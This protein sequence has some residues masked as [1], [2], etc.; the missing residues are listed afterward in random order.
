MKAKL[1]GLLGAQGAFL[2]LLVAGAGSPASAQSVEEL[3]D[4]TVTSARVVTV[5]RSQIGGPKQEISL[6]RGV[7]A[8][9]L[10][11]ATPE[12]MAALETRVQQMAD[13]LCAELDRLYPMEEPEARTCARDAVRRTMSGVRSRLAVS[14]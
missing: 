7:I 2:A 5:G 12:G 8:D 11:L 9:D 3:E 13:T 6:T 4:I 1:P 10:D 14:E